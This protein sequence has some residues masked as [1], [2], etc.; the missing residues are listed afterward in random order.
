[1]QLEIQS[2][3]TAAVLANLLVTPKSTAEPDCCIV[4]RIFF[5]KMTQK[6]GE[7]E[8]TFVP[9]PGPPIRFLKSPTTGGGVIHTSK[10]PNPQSGVVAE[11]VPKNPINVIFLRS[12]T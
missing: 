11:H 8:Q 4:V 6:K 3:V 5:L 7:T 12:P 2:G 9:L 1:M 10:P